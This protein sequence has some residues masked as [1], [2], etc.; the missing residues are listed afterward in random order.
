MNKQLQTLS[1]SPAINLIEEW[2]WLLGV[3]SFE[4]TN[5]VFNITD[6]NNS[7][8]ISTS[9]HWNSEDG[10]Q[11]FYKINKLLELK[12]E[13]D[14]QLHAKE[15]EKRGARIEIENSGY[16][17]A[18][19][20]HLKSE[21]LAELKKVKYKDL[22]VMVY[23]I[24]LTSDEIVDIL[25]VKYIAGSTNGYT[26]PPGIYETTDIILM[27]KSVLP[28]KIKVNITIDDIILKSILTT[29]KTIRFSKKSFSIKY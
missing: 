24:Q 20:D 18:R 15:V 12:S 11:L 5:S 9:A 1:F 28:S 16:D 22:D 29:N 21:I 8:A 23:R 14:I 26:L 6:E 17:L 27:V 4:T 25:F 13:N 7:F 2:K 19:F 10:A 3:T